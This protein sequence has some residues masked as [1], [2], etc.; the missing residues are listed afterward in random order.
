MIDRE[1]VMK[2]KVIII[3]DEDSIRSFIRINFQRDNFIVLEAASAEEGI[4]IISQEKPDI[5]LL[6]VMLPGMDGF[7]ACELIRKEFAD[8]GIIMLT[9]RA[10]DMDKIMGLEFGADDYLVKPFNPM[11]LLLRTKAILRRMK[12]STH[13]NKGEIINRGPFEIN[14]YSQ[15]IYKNGIELYLTP[16]E[17]MLMK[18]FVE[19]PGK[20]F[21][22]DKLLDLVWGYEFFGDTKIV[23]VNIRRLRAK[24]EESSSSPMYIET[25][26]GTGYRWRN[27]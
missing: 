22:R 6:D 21:T 23:D 14:T 10:Q 15:I 27:E 11:E 19:N 24:I 3:E 26:W 2:N 17:Y 13:N 20:A 12:D 9:A 4:R 16:K 18:I 1:I 7:K 25:V 5:I 8:I